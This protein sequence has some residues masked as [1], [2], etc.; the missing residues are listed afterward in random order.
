MMH[1]G[2]KQTKTQEKQTIEKLVGRLTLMGYK[3]HT[4]GSRK[5]KG[6]YHT[7]SDYDFFVE[8]PDTPV[9][10]G[11]KAKPF[12]ESAKIIS[13]VERNGFDFGGSEISDS[14]F[15]SFKKHG[16]DTWN[17][18]FAWGDK[19]QQF[20]AAQEMVES[21]QVTNKKDRITIHEFLRSDSFVDFNG[22]EVPVV[23]K[24]AFEETVNKYSVGKS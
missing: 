13:M 2:W 6:G 5:V 10:S 8:L 12:N 15:M 3:V 11:L 19:V 7:A 22:K 14:N 24:E 16:N 1:Y 23:S 17:F 21:L 20:L 18:I 9:W 4:V